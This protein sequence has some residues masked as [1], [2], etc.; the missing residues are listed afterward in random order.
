[1]ERK[2]RPKTFKNISSFP[3]PEL[4]LVHSLDI[5]PETSKPHRIK[6]CLIKL[7]SKSVDVYIILVAI[8]FVIYCPNVSSAPSFKNF[9]SLR[10]PRSSIE[11][12]VAENDKDFLKDLTA[13][14]TGYG[15]YG[16]HGG[17]GHHGGHAGSYGHH[18]KYGSE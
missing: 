7:P 15:G 6:S 8:C 11:V 10:S 14:A 5:L 3:S 16:G 9:K 13:D 12:Q 4:I 17:Y 1:M 18:G 2:R